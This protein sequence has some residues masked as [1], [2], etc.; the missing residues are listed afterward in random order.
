MPP[1]TVTQ[2]SMAF[3][4]GGKSIR[5]D[6]YLPESPDGPLP[7][8][9]ALHGSGGG[10]SGMERYAGMLAAQGFAAY[11]LHYFDRAAIESANKPMTDEK[12]AMQ[13]ILLQ[14]IMI[15]FPLW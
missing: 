7:A 8:V 10:V 2:S 15:N 9:I 13:K 1:L 4:S 11:I 14:K 12:S 5:L 3:E 6:G